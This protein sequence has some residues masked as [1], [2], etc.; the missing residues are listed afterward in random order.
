MA[1]YKRQLY[2]E[3]INEMLNLR[4]FAHRLLRPSQMTFLKA[5]TEYRREA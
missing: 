3:I 2:F 4:T 5:K 1:E